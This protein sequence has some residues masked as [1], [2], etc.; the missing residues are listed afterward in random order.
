M[1]ENNVQK[2]LTEAFRQASGSDVR[3]PDL[4]NLVSE[5]LPRSLEGLSGALTDVSKQLDNVRTASQTQSETTGANTQAVLQNTV[6]QNNGGAKGAIG[7][8][9]KTASG[10]FGS[11][12]VLGPVFSVLGKLFSGGKTEA[13]P[14]LVKF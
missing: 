3:P 2:I 12:L 11:G 14:P 5:F 10:L 7:T 6:A 4:T 9:A 8:V 1:P 13:P